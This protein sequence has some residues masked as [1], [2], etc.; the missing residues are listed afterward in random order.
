MLVTS[1]DLKIIIHWLLLR[2]LAKPP[3]L[4]CDK[5]PLAVYPYKYEVAYEIFAVSVAR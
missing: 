4:T 3:G 2:F 5:P 1:Y